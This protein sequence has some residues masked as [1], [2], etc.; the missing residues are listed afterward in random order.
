MIVNAVLKEEGDY[1]EFLLDVEYSLVKGN[2]SDLEVFKGFKVPRAD[3]EL[4]DS[5]KPKATKP[6]FRKPKL[7]KVV[8]GGAVL[9]KADDDPAAGEAGKVVGGAALS[10]ADHDK[11]IEDC[12]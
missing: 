5:A 3:G 10:N 2:Q 4:L 8:V 11:V 7:G 9:G 1:S 12:R 6:K